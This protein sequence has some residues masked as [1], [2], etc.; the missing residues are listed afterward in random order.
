MAAAFEYRVGWEAS[1]MHGFEGYTEWTPWD[2]PETS[3]E[4]IEAA[5]HRD[6]AGRHGS[7]AR[8]LGEAM[9]GAGFGWNVEVR[10]VAT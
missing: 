3:I 7:V 6:D 9:E 10:S 5:L 1:T 2:G 8:G 4:D